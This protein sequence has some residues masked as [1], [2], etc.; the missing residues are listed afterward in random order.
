MLIAL[1]HGDDYITLYA[2]NQ[3]LLQKNGDV[4]F[5]GDAIALAGHSGGQDKNSLYFELSHKGKQQNPL[6]WLKPRKR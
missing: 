2:Y 1:D 6:K 4:V 5:S 3:T